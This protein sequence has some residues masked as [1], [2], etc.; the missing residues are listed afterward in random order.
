MQPDLVV[1]IAAL[2]G[3]GLFAGVLAG[4]FGI[5]GG[6]VIVPVLEA[7]LASLGV[8]PAIRMHVAVATSLATIIPTS[9]ASSLAHYR[10]QSVDL[11]VVKRW[12]AFIVIGTF[13]GAWFAAGVDSTV[14]AI[15]F[16]CVTFLIA[17]RTLSHYEPGQ[18][19]AEVP[20]T[21]VVGVIPVLIGAISTVMGIGGGVMSV[22]AL[23]IFGQPVRRAVG[24]AA[25]LGL[26][27]AV[28]GT[29]GMVVAGWDDPRL[30]AWTA[31]FV[32]LPGVLAIAPL[33]VLAAPLGARLAHRIPEKVTQRLFGAFL[34]LVSARLFFR[35]FAES[36]G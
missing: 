22:I 31:G 7:V 26:A 19:A 25:L 6:I 3:A 33:T 10:R 32:S 30:P 29:L 17:L 15:I 2:A 12:S 24:T 34:L 35:V 9:I 23:R 27:I 8:D 20:S 18:L 1:L 5:G 14:L 4:L 28:P 36:G 11:P 16:A 13:L 21:P